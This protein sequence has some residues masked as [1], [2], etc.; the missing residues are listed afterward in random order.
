MENIF[1][2]NPET[3]YQV[4]ESSEGYWIGTIS[5]DVLSLLLLFFL[6]SSVFPSWLLDRS[7]SSILPSF[8]SFLSQAP[9][10][11]SLED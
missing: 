6:P 7:A 1:V 5:L 10:V 9:R 3:H 4:L 8:L 2:E 11:N